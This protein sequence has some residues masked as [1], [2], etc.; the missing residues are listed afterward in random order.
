MQAL[1]ERIFSVRRYVLEV[2]ADPQ[3]LRVTEVW[4]MEIDNR[5][6][7]RERPAQDIP[8]ELAA[9]WGNQLQRLKQRAEAQAKGTS[10]GSTSDGKLRLKPR[11]NNGD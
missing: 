9:F 8:R 4:H 5:Q 2:D 1:R 10:T 3:T 11:C 6:H 7:E